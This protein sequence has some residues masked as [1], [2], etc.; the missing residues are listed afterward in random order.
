M[1][2]RSRSKLIFILNYRRNKMREF[3]NTEYKPVTKM[4]HFTY[5]FRG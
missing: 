1:L 4:Y 5:V 2:Y 3:K